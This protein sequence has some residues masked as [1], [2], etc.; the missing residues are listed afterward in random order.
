[1]VLPVMTT[2]AIASAILAFPFVYLAVRHRRLGRCF[3]IMLGVVLLEIVVVTPLL[4]MLGFLGAFP[5]LAL[6]LVLCY[7]RTPKLTW[8]RGC[9]ACGYEIAEGVGPVCSECGATLPWMTKAPA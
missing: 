7:Y 9:P 3:L 2:V 1:M 6:A 8:P 5:A 4:G